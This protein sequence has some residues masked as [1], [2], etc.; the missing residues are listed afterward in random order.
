MQFFDFDFENIMSLTPCLLARGWAGEAESDIPAQLFP[1]HVQVR[2]RNNKLLL[3]T[4]GLLSS[5]D[6]FQGL[7]ASG[8]MAFLRDHDSLQQL[9]AQ[10]SVPDVVGEVRGPTR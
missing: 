9:A 1:K 7:H 8:D 10:R 5:F 6:P 4:T 3:N 2:L